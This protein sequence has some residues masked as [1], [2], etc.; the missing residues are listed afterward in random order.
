MR[1]A[2]INEDGICIGVSD[3]S[4][5]VNAAHMIPIGPDGNPIGHTWTGGEWIAPPPPPT[6][7]RALTKAEFS[8]LVSTG[9]TSPEKLA[10]RTDTAMTLA[11]LEI[12]DLGDA[13]PRDH[14]FTTNFL[15]DATGAQVLTAAQRAAV[16]EGWPK[17]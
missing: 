15:N 5:E 12:S 16:L 8:S 2:Q 3:L 9:L 17:M 11:W 7:Y 13:I 10:L 1:Y 4:G 14:E 6:S